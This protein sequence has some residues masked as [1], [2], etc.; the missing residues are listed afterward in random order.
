MKESSQEK[1]NR[2]LI[3]GRVIITRVDDEQITASVRGSDQDYWAGYDPQQGRWWCECPARGRCC[4][5]LAVMRVT[6]RPY[7]CAP[8]GGSARGR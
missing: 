6:R 2:Y 4:H 7:G 1:A 5:L 8:F 3:E